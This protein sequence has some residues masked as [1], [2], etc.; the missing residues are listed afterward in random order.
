[1]T[2][3]YYQNNTVLLSSYQFYIVYYL[4]LCSKTHQNVLHAQ[5]DR[6]NPSGGVQPTHSYQAWLIHTLDLHTATKLGLST[7]S[8]NTHLSSLAYPHPRSTHSYQAWLIH[9]LDQHTATKLG[10]ST[11]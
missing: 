11:P 8:I 9:T 5:N 10:L 7:P 6:G 2:P 3:L 1:M 4:K